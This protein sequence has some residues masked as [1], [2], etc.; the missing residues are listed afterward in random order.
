MKAPRDDVRP[1]WVEYLPYLGGF[2]A[3]AG[4]V[5]LIGLIIWLFVTGTG[6]VNAEDTVEGFG[7]FIKLLKPWMRGMMAAFSMLAVGLILI[8]AASADRRTPS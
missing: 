1:R 6:Q 4:F 2:L 5:S 7:R 3:L 8:W